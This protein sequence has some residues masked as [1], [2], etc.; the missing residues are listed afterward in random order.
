M[1]LTIK[2]FLKANPKAEIS[3]VLSPNEV[4]VEC[5]VNRQAILTDPIYRNHNDADMPVETHPGYQA[6]TL[7]FSK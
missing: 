4:V 5:P 2:D 6:I 1:K 7:K 3:N